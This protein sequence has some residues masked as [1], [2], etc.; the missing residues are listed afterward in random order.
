MKSISTLKLKLN[1]ES[2]FGKLVCFIFDFL[3]VVTKKMTI[4]P[5][6]STLRHKGS[7]LNS[8]TTSYKN[9]CNPILT[10]MKTKRGYKSVKCSVL[11]SRNNSFEKKSFHLNFNSEIMSGNNDNEG[12]NEEFQ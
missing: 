5:E 1:S 4:E 6:S 12:A 11:P 3:N 9:G 7:R 10:N 8:S 2:A